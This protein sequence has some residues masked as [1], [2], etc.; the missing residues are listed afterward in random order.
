MNSYLPLRDVLIKGLKF[1]SQL[2]FVPEE[3]FPDPFTNKNDQEIKLHVPLTF[4]FAGSYQ[5][6]DLF[7]EYQ[8]LLEYKY[9]KHFSDRYYLTTGTDEH[10]PNTLNNRRFTVT[11]KVKEEIGFLWPIPPLWILEIEL[12]YLNK[13]VDRYYSF[14]HFCDYWGLN[15]L[16]RITGNKGI[17]NRETAFAPF[18]TSDGWVIATQVKSAQPPEMFSPLQ[19]N[20]GC[21]IAVDLSSIIKSEDNNSEISFP[22]RIIKQK[23]ANERWNN[24]SYLLTFTLSRE[25]INRINSIS[26]RVDV[27]QM[28]KFYNNIICQKDSSLCIN[29]EGHFNLNSGIDI[30]EM[31]INKDK[32]DYF[33]GS[34]N[35]DSDG[36]DINS[37][38]KVLSLSGIVIIGIFLIML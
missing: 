8:R 17:N 26:I 14:V 32:Q 31:Y 9:N 2:Q 20:S 24:R 5:E 18:R 13:K 28:L 38:F 37:V 7:K 19:E 12:Q 1:I 11:K 35:T 3:A 21:D 27:D 23:S 15:D 4:Q 30:K 16:I 36:Q 29:N 22:V 10:L 34:T 6:T 25:D 33:V